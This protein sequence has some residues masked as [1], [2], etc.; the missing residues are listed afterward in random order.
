MSDNPRI[1]DVSE[2]EVVPRPKVCW[3]S[4]FRRA[5]DRA[6]SISWRGSSGSITRT[7]ATPTWRRAQPALPGCISSSKR[8][9]MPTRW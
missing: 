5:I 3:R 2:L 6:R 8:S 7:S 4:W 1:S 9:T